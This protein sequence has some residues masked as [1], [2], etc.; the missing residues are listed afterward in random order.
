[1]P[2]DF[3]RTLDDEHVVHRHLQLRWCDDPGEP[4]VYS[5]QLDVLAADAPKL[6]GLTPSLAIIDELGPGDPVRAIP[7]KP[8]KP[9]LCGGFG[10]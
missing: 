8:E 3:A 1:M 7:R 4:K 5:R 6:H 9:P 2:W 10:D